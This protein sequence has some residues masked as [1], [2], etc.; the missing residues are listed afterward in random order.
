MAALDHTA[1]KRSRGVDLSTWPPVYDSAYRPAPAAEHWLPE[2]ECAAPAARDELIFAK[3]QRQLRYAWERSPFYRRKWQDAGVSPN[4]LKSLDDLARFPA[5]QKAE[6]RAAQEVA[7]PFGDY[8]CIEASEVARIHGTSGTTGRPTVFGIGAEDWRRIGEAH[9]RVLWGAGLRPEDRILI[10]SFFSLYLGS[11][12]ALAGGERLGAAVFPFGAGVPGQTLMAVQWARDLK[13]TAFY[14]TPSYALHFAETAKREGIDPRSLG[15]CILFFSGEPGA[16]IPATKALIEKTFGGI[17]VDMG[18]MAEMT[19]WM[20]NG[21]CRHRTGMHLW[22]D[23]VYTQVCDP[24]TF[25]PLPYGAEGTPV[26]THLERTSQPMIRLVSGD[27]ARWMNDPCPCGR[28]YPRLPDG[29]YGRFDDM[30]IVRGE[31]VYPSVVED[32]LRAIEGFGGEFRMIV[33][34]REAMDELL[35][36]AEFSASHAEPARLA[37]VART[38]KERLRARLGVHPVIDLVPEGTLPRTEF[39]AR[40][41]IDDRDLYR[42]TLSKGDKNV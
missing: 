23:L 8:L 2:V 17:C 27:R 21:E 6:L 32:T 33:S 40:R 25:Q 26:Y 28:T 15:F 30:I 22:Q 14:G 5:V 1:L 13:P 42:Q 35:I 9:A 36:R 7:P 12:G 16:G 39:K 41:V 34:R 18:S 20:T 19:P 37:A 11:W 31:N 3:L 29:L 38:M 24:E 10:C 4:T